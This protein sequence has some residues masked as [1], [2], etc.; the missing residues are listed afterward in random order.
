MKL[1][2]DR[3]RALLDHLGAPDRRLGT[4]VHVA[5]T[6]GKGST[7]AILAALVRGCGK[8]VATY[9]SPHLSTLR[10][11]ITIDGELVSEH[12]IVEAAARVEAAGGGELTFFEQITAIAMLIIA[13]AKV[14]VT[15]LEVGLGGRL[16]ATNVVDARTAPVAVIT[17]VAMD[18]EAIL[19]NSLDAIARE[20]AGIVK[21]GQR[22]IIG[23]SGEPAA[24]PLLREL[25]FA[26][27][28]ARVTVID[29]S[30]IARVPPVALA[31]VHQRAN[32]AA[33]LAALDDL[34]MAPVPPHDIA[35]ILAGVT[36]PGRFEV[37]GD[38][39]SGV[40]LDGAH[41]PH[42]A[43]ALAT[44]LR[45][46]AIRPVL[47]VAVSSDKDI[48]AIADALLPEV[49]AVIAT[50]YQQERA[51]DPAALANAFRAV[52]HRLHEDSR[53]EGGTTSG[54]DRRIA[55]ID[56]FGDDRR[57]SSDGLGDDR[58]ATSV[59]RDD[60]RRVSN[61]PSMTRVEVAVDL[62][63]ALARARVLGGSIL[64]AGSLFLV[65]EARVLLLGAPAD[66]IA[67]SDPAKPAS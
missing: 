45:A 43:R 19:G 8:R 60:E 54:R 59:H 31:G 52:A 44:T 48:R 12:A 63:A 25:A 28:A 35:E 13:D 1:G 58:G 56:F 46:R 65:G 23:A 37:I 32:A 30:A 55:Q 10:E 57:S 18:H 2:L 47:I 11:R 5:G 9:T 29:D 22:V 7:V 16:D 41:N 24:V 14:D 34:E 64:V 6:N 33:A 38:T 67:I 62:E 49:S 17:G 40:I 27:G 26:A 4:V 20:K 50:R 21:A 51:L 53:V 66:P 3:I 39:Q 61:E 15:I 36:H 42:G